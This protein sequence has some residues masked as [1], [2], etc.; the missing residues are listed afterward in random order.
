MIT[1]D[2]TYK[3]SKSHPPIMHLHWPWHGGPGFRV[4]DYTD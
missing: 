2:T 1:I 4:A 3:Y